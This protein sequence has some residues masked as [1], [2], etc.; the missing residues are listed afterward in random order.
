[1]NLIR[2]LQNFEININNKT[3]KEGKGNVLTSNIGAEETQRKIKTNESMSEA[4]ALFGKQFTKILKQVDR[5][6]RT[7]D[8]HIMSNIK[9]QQ[10]NMR[11][12]KTDGNNNQPKGVQCSKCEGYGHLKIECATYI[13]KQKKNLVVSWSDEDNS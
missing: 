2:S 11:K 6:S 5:E 12:F 9:G 1:M 8:Q 7:N 13:K 10:N 3:E 4:I